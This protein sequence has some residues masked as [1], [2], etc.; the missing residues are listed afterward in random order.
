MIG[1]LNYANLKEHLNEIENSINLYL[2]AL[3][4]EAESNKNY[5]LV[6]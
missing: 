3:K 5:I 4:F 6:N 2:S 1:I